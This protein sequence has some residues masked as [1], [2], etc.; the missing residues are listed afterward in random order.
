MSEKNVTFEFK[1]DPSLKKKESAE[2][3]FP[4][5]KIQAAAYTSGTNLIYVYDAEGNKV[6]LKGFRFDVAHIDKL[7][8]IAGATHIHF[9]VAVSPTNPSNLTLIAGAGIEGIAGYTIDQSLL[10]D[11]CEPC[12]SKCPTNI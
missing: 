3:K 12:P 11:F 7:V 4:A 8:K 5:A 2:I 1:S 10:F 9:V 6:P